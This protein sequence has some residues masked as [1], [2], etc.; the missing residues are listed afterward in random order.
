[1]DGGDEDELGCEMGEVCSDAEGVLISE[2]L[3]VERGGLA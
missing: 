2:D 1:V 3:H